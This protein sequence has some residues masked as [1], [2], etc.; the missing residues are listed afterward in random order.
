[1]EGGGNLF[2]GKEN[3]TFWGRFK[4]NNNLYAGIRYGF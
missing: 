4:K 3:H 2:W 1:V